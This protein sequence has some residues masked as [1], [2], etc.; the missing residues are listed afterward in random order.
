MAASTFHG[1]APCRGQ[2]LLLIALSLLLT[3]AAL[4]C[5]S[6]AAIGN[7]T[8]GTGTG[9][10]TGS[11]GSTPQF[12]HI[13]IVME[14]NAS[15]N[16]VIGSSA[17][18]Y[19]NGLADKYGLA[20][21][22][23]ANTHPSIGNY[24]MIT[25][26]KTI[27]NDDGFS[28]TVSDDNLVRQFVKDGKSW[29]TYQESIPSAGYLGGDAY[30]YLKHHNPFAYFSDVTGDSSLANN[31]VPFSNFSQDVSSG[32]LPNFAFVVPN[33]EHDAHDC[34]SGG[35]LCQ[36]Q[37]KLATA[38]TWLQNHI[39]PLI[40]SAAFSDTLLVIVF[41]EGDGADFMNGGGHVAAVLVSPKGKMNF[42]SSTQFQ[43][44]NLERLIGD[45]LRL[46]SIP[47]AGSTA[48]GMGEFF[49]QP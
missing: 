41:D 35:Q 44:Q 45:A 24:F 4:A 32:N 31:I 46:S 22:Y 13:V 17:M 19:L 11:S 37:D 36:L 33:V 20:T 43:H 34:P 48:A 2:Q 3:C 7:T 28:G 29:K 14:E 26:G 30:P 38:D 27:T 25:T 10:S 42:Q 15:Y 5:G 12:S 23:Y 8:Q 21:Q 18:P 1:R 49:S 40:G 47:G 16:D 39:D 9:S 6:T